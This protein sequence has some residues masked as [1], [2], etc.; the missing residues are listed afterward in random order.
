[1]SFIAAL[2]FIAN[3]AAMTGSSAASF[4][5]AKKEISAQKEIN[6][7]QIG[8]AREQ[9]AFQERLA[10]TAHAREVVD[11]RNAGLNP[12]LSANSGAASPSGTMAILRNPYEGLSEKVTGGINNV[13]NSARTIA[14]LN[15]T[16]EQ[17]KTQQTQQA[18]NSAAAAKTTAEA[19]YANEEAKNASWLVPARGAGGI[20]GSILGFF[21]QAR[22][23]S[24][25]TPRPTIAPRR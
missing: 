14:D 3:A 4:F 11:L 8:L 23:N 24:G 2:P 6:E 19:A 12:I 16:K 25:K 10:N 17:I 13:M 7:E 22:K 21:S 1:M 18:L 5:S 9:M 20:L 15:L